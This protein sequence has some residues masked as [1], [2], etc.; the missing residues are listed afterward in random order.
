VIRGSLSTAQE[1]FEAT[2]LGEI[3]I[4]AL[5]ALILLI[6]IGWSMP[7]SAL[8]QKVVTV[9]EPA[10]LLSGL[11]QA[12]FM[13]APDPY[14]RLETVEVHVETVDGEERVWAFPSGGAVTQFTWYRWHKLKEQAVKIPEIRDD[15]VRWA[16][17]Q[18]LA[19]TDYPAVASMVLTT[20]D[21]PP[22]GSG[23]EP[24]PALTDVL[25]TETL[26]GPP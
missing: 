20:E 11:D 25:Y 19:P 10:A 5:I 21:F 2:R 14:R 17:D 1:R 4:S 13:F 9:V 24:G 22:P 3:V 7:D 8:R 18:V 26:A 6:A 12:W 15:I 23:A 16:A